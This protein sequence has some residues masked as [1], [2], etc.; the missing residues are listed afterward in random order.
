MRPR[1]DY[2][3]AVTEH[4]GPPGSEGGPVYLEE[5][6]TPY[7]PDEPGPLYAEFP[8]S[9]A[10]CCTGSGQRAYSPAG[11]GSW[12]FWSL[13]LNAWR[14]S[15][16]RSSPVRSARS[17]IGPSA[18]SADNIETQTSPLG[19][20]L[21]WP[22]S[23]HGFSRAPLPQHPSGRARG[24]AARARAIVAEAGRWLTRNSRWRRPK[25]WHSSRGQHAPLLRRAGTR[26]GSA[27]ERTGA[28]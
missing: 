11:T 27:R 19:C 22:N 17:G 13:T 23:G 3:P 14:P 9:C 20:A 25:R 8:Y 24:P 15:L 7:T 1:V 26:S 21:S 16:T 10:L 6:E 18:S 2:V 5:R 4:P 12:G 28:G